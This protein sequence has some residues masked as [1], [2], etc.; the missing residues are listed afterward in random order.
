MKPTVFIT[1][2][3]KERMKAFVAGVY[4]LE[5]QLF[6]VERIKVNTSVRDARY[7]VGASKMYLIED[8][9]LDFANVHYPRFFSH[10]EWPASDDT[11]EQCLLHNSKHLELLLADVRVLYVRVKEETHSI[12]RDVQVFLF[13]NGLPTLHFCERHHA[14]RGEMA[15]L[16]WYCSKVLECERLLSE[17]YGRV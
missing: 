17:Y 12:L 16:E 7:T 5:M 6:E 2:E 14:V 11:R 13:P 3:Y 15:E 4:S 1:P 10:A 8:N 9:L